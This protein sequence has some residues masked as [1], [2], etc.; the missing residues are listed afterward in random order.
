MTV[1]M[2]H[3]IQ[4]RKNDAQKK[5]KEQIK[6]CLLIKLVPL[7]EKEILGGYNT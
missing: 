1:E 4:N 2:A 5:G 7:E 3:E 6:W